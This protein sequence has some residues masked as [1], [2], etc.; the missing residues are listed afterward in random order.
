MPTE[1]CVYLE[2]PSSG[3]SSLPSLRL[4][5]SFHSRNPHTLSNP[6]CVCVHGSSLTSMPVQSIH[7]L[8]TFLRQSFRT[9]LHMLSTGYESTARLCA[10]FIT[11]LYACPEYPPSSNISQ[12]KLPYFI[13][14]ALHWLSIHCMSVCTVRHSPLCFS[15]VSTFFQRFSG[16]ASVFHHIRHAL[17]PT[18]LHPSV[19]FAALVLLQCLKARFPTA[20]GSSGHRLFIS[21]F[22]IAS[23]IRSG[24][25]A[26]F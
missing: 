3:A 15:R 14:N 10:R 26:N 5:H 8:P 22:M 13:A 1:E 6:P 24:G 7:L 9:S 18:R 23:R 12:A 20:Q 16:E 19:T 21:A 17:R 25:G 2:M 11:H 4:S